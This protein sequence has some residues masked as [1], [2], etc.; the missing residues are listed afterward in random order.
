MRENQD[1][2]MAFVSDDFEG[3]LS[4]LEDAIED[5]FRYFNNIV[6][7]PI[8]TNILPSDNEVELTFTFTRRVES[9][10]SGQILTDEASTYMIFERTEDG[11]RVSAMAA[12]LIFGL[13]NA[14][15][16]ATVV[17]NDSIGQQVIAVNPETGQASKVTQQETVEATASAIE[18]SENLSCDY[19]FNWATVVLDFRDIYTPELVMTGWIPGSGM[20]L[21]GDRLYLTQWS[22]LWVYEL[23]GDPFEAE[24]LGEYDMYGIYN[25]FWGV[26]V[27]N[28]LI[29]VR[30]G[31][32]G[33]QIFHYVYDT[34]GVREEDYVGRSPGP[35][36]LLVLEGGA[37]KIYLDLPN[38]GFMR[39][40]AYDV[41]GRYLGE[42]YRG[43][44][45]S[46]RRD[47]KVDLSGLRSG[48]YFLRVEGPGIDEIRRVLLVR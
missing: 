31:G 10:R 16:V 41:V 22:H 27:E 20:L 9:S 46:G 15:E 36:D 6:I 1:G 4:S 37:G 25:G 19:D 5:D 28:N 42:V 11:Y 17:D 48:V 21:V 33:L 13:S 32:R 45:S 40:E 23:S 12:P 34:V 35:S 8:I 26:D 18:G 44:L 3:D 2:F 38:S 7:R 24:C 30:T 14:E 39:V 29:Y 43:Y 47:V